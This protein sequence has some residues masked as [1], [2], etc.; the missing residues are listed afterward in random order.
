MKN[1]FRSRVILLGIEQDDPRT[2]SIT[3]SH[4]EFQTLPGNRAVF[5]TLY[6][7]D[8]ALTMPGRTSRTTSL[9]EP[10]SSLVQDVDICS[11]WYLATSL[12][13]S[14]ASNEEQYVRSSE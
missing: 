10:T 14:I 3:T 2:E 12:S 7:A 9:L 8:L 11:D 6:G 1:A 4:T 5:N 13:M